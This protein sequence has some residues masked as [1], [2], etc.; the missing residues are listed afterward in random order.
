M[1]LR[2]AAIALAFALIPIPAL[3]P[4][5]ALA[6]ATKPAANAPAPAAPT[7]SAKPAANA[8]APTSSALTADLVPLKQL[9]DEIQQAIGHPGQTDQSLTELREKLAP[10]RDGLRAQFD[11]LDPRLAEVDSRLSELGPA[12]AAGQ[13]PEAATIAE[14]R[15]KLSQTHAEVDGALKETRLLSLH[16]DDIAARIN[17]SRR[18]LFSRALFQRTP[19]VLDTGFWSETMRGL[20]TENQGISFLI[21]SS[22]EY[23]QRNGSTWGVVGSIATLIAL[24]ALAIAA[25]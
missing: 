18:S 1:L 16:A 5:A 19:G 6:Q 2:R 23:A 11:V 25:A 9:L 12:P 20:Q 13:P 8:P 22:T 4:P 21:R 17:E 10:I 14:E 24:A 3:A 7:R 15:A